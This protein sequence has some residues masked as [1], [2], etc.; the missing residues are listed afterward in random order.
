MLSVTQVSKQ[1]ADQ[2]SIHV[3]FFIAAGMDEYHSRVQ[4]SLACVQNED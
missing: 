3:P 1:A 4:R 2:V